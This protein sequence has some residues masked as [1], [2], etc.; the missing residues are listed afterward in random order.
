MTID[1]AVIVLSSV[2]KIDLV[3]RSKEHLRGIHR[4]V[5]DLLH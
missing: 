1:L 4:R 2:G 3:E 5:T